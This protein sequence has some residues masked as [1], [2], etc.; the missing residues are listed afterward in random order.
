MHGVIA[1]SVETDAVRSKK[2]SA[3][4]QTYK[5]N[6]AHLRRPRSPTRQRLDPARELPDGAQLDQEQIG[7]LKPRA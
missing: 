6:P 7:G 1:L 3:D 5:T 4:K 2:S